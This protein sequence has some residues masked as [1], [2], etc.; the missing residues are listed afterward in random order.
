VQLVLASAPYDE[1]DYIR[2][3]DDFKRIW[4]PK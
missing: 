4:G 2:N 3:Y 1:Q